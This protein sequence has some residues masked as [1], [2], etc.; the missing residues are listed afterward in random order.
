MFHLELQKT[1][2]Q[3]TGFIMG[4]S[5]S[6][7]GS[8]SAMCLLE[9]LV[10]GQLLTIDVCGYTILAIIPLQLALPTEVRFL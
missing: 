2:L 6:P 8:G 3:A 10:S 4:F 7:G 1:K 9:G 5:L